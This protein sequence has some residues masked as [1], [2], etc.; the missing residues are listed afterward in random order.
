MPKCADYPGLVFP[1]RNKI[2]SASYILDR[3]QFGLARLGIDHKTRRLTIHCLR[4]TYNTLMKT[5]L[6]GDILI[7]FLGHKSVDMT[8]HYDNLILL[9]RLA[10]YR[11]MQSR[12][13]GFWDAEANKMI[14][15][16]AS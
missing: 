11:N 6:P 3:F 16:K 1:Y 10:A 12:V 14:D 15:F 4:Y 5:K 2:V 7:E 13:D 8:D 9:E